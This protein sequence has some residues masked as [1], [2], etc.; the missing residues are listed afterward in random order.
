MINVST[1]KSYCVW[2]SLLYVYLIQMF[3]NLHG[4]F[5]LV[6]R[7]CYHDN[8]LKEIMSIDSVS[9]KICELR[10]SG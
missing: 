2:Y 7:H 6:K 1:C 5:T 10:E 8:L 3:I 9:E 4:H